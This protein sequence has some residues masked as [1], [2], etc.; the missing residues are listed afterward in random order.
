MSSSSA[1]A[2]QQNTA[3]GSDD[4]T[5][6]GFVRFLGVGLAVP[7]SHQAGSLRPVNALRS[8]LRRIEEVKFYDD[9]DEVMALAERDGCAQGLR[10]A[11]KKRKGI[12]TAVLTPNRVY[13][14]STAPGDAGYVCIELGDRLEMLKVMATLPRIMGVRTLSFIDFRDPEP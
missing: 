14:V 11:L 4:Q 10:D 3:I 1:K 7:A 6:L 13:V 5:A 9:D 12:S 2:H 8:E